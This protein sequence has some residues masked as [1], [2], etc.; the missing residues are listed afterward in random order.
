MRT[1]SAPTYQTAFEKMAQFYSDHEDGRGAMLSLELFPN[2]A[3][4][5]VPD[6]ATAYPWRDTVAHL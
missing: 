5:A 2:E 3:A 1:L 6:D 4:R